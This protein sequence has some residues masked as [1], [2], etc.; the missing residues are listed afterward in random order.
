[1]SYLWVFIGGGLGSVVRFGIS[2]ASQGLYGGAFPLGTFISNMLACILLAV[3]IVF[4]QRNQQMNWFE[5]FVLIGFCGG[6]STFSTFSNETLDLFQS[7]HAVIAI[8]N[9]I[10]SVAVGLGLI[11]WLRGTV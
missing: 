11:Y 8:A 7:G 3:A 5:P 6:F 1:M 9:I 10:V 2:R 4:L